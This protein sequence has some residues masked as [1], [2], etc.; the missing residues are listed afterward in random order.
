MFVKSPLIFVL[1]RKVNSFYV[2]ILNCSKKNSKIFLVEDWRFYIS[3]LVFLHIYHKKVC[4]FSVYFPVMLL[5]TV[6]WKS[7]FSR[8]IQC[9]ETLQI[10]IVR[11]YRGIKH[12]V[13]SIFP[14]IKFFTLQQLHEF[15][16]KLGQFWVCRIILFNII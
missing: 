15:K 8:L 13:N 2:R 11:W 14:V 10:P 6:H 16:K 5:F 1:T 4:E 9:I 12:E 3:C 7:T